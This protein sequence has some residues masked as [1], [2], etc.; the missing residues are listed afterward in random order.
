MSL[1]STV[2]SA[3][4][5]YRIES[6]RIVRHLERANA[7]AA[8]AAVWFDG[9]KL[10]LHAAARVNAVASDAAAS[11]DSDLRS[12]AHIGTIA[13]TVAVALGETTEA[14]GSDIL[15]AMV[16]GYEIAGRIDESLT[17]GRLKNGFHGS[18][19]TVFAGAVAAGRL[20]KL[21]R[22]ANGTSDR[23]RRD[24]DRRHRHFRRH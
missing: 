7:G 10:P 15:A 13:S 6:A 5:G 22:T 23:A 21:A 9:T 11:D 17:P 4:M 16:L 8:L 20:L 3:A 14:A 2:A 18:V 1:A 19:S 24:L 12:I